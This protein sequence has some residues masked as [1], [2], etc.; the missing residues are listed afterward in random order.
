[1]TIRP[2]VEWGDTVDRPGDLVVC[3]GD[4]ELAALVAAGDPRPLAVGAG[5]LARTAGSPGHRDRVQRVP[6]DAL[7]VVADGVEHVAVAHVVARRR[8]WLG[9]IVA[10]CNAEWMGAWDVAPRAHPNDG[11]ADVVEVAASMPVRARF[12]ARRR[13]PTGT[14]VP[15]PDIRTSRTADGTWTF[16]AGTRLWIDGVPRGRV[17][18]LQVRVDADAF[19]LHV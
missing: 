14:H 1:M 8:T 10:V 6:V 7:R 4:A 19:E 12:Q 13:L 3:A 9:R 17:R 16:G 5:D 18:E 11:V 15:H 2:G